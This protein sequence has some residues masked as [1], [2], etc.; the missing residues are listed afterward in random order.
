MDTRVIKLNPLK[1]NPA[2]ITEAAAMID[3]GMLVSF[4]T[5][6]V[7]GIA[8]RTAA[9]TV[10]K[11]NS[12]KGR[13]PDKFYTLHIGD[14]EDIHKYLPVIG[15]R[16]KKLIENYWPGPL[17]IIFELSAA[18]MEKQKSILPAD[19][20]NLLYNNNTI[21]IR[22]PDNLIASALLRSTK[23]AVVAP[24][25][26]V[27]GSKPS[28]NASEVL[29]SF[30]GQID[31]ILDGGE[32]KY[33]FS[34]T[35]IKIAKAGI[36]ILRPGVVAAAEIKKTANITIL[37]VCTGNTCRS[38]MAEGMFK[39]QLSENTGIN[40]DKTAE[41]GYNIVSAGTLGIVGLPASVEAV[42]VCAARGVDLSGHRSG[43]LS[44][45]LIEQ[46]DVIFALTSSHRREVISLCPEAAE[47]CFLLAAGKDI[48]DPIGQSSQVYER[49]ADMIEDAV[50]QR[51]SEMDL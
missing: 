26:N 2:A 18:Q 17:T 37:F 28:V 22:C 21:G 16:A 31:M 42:E 10:A 4:P 40:I 6:T 49:C 12:L 43:A 5:E 14:V 25:A 15:L 48:P 23:H 32:C 29:K 9:D 8:C 51:L 36:E 7:Y 46:S 45:D 34:S 24:S 39:K 3:I 19:V 33:K 50:K 41:V 13:T 38:P 1:P 30:C 20:F 47:K 35:V 27:T 11:L 44:K